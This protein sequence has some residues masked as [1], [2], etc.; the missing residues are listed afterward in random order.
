[1]PLVRDQEHFE[2][3][4]FEG[5]YFWMRDS[6]TQIL[7]KVS[8]EALRDRSAQDGGNASLPDTFI[9]HRQQIEMIAGA[10][11]ERGHRTNDLILVFSRELTPIPT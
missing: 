7:C 10:K 8:H 4:R 5:I 2:F 3:T 9:R 1:M 6:A 11:Y